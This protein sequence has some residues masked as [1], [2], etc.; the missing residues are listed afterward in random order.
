MG[1]LKKYMPSTRMTFLL[2]TFAI[3]GIPLFSGFFSKDEILFR[4]FEASSANGWAMFAW[5]V[6][7]VTAFL[8]AIYM[9]RV[10]VLTF[11]GEPR[12]PRAESIHPHESPWTM[13]LPLWILGI[14]AVIGG[15]VGLPGVF[16]HGEYNLIHHF[17]G[18]E[19]GGPVAEAAS[20]AHVA[21]STEWLL[22]LLGAVIALAG[23][24][25]GWRW[26]A[27]RGLEYDAVLAKRFGW[28]YRTAKGK[29]YVDEAY[30]KVVVRPVIGGAE[31]GFAPFD[32]FVVD[33]LVNF[34]A[35][36]TKGISFVLRYLQSG[37]VQ[38]YAMAIVLG[39]VLVAALM[40]FG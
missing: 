14:L 6:G 10:Y 33:G 26:F 27:R 35:F 38:T 17:L 13:T 28:F 18:E 12:W 9:I 5:I 37:V 21:L 25:L 36:F 30:D 8:T 4:A 20:E 19:F 24:G 40:L 39:V 31:K 16:G 22:L 23:V 7:I 32:Q 34:V 1:G 3:A 29:Y 2:S 11:E 15:Y